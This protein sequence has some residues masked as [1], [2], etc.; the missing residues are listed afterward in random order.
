MAL[1]II[2]ALVLIPPVV[3]ILGWAPKWLFVL[4]LIAVVERS[5]YEFVLINRR[6]GIQCFAGLSYC[7]GGLLCLAQLSGLG[8]RFRA[9]ALVVIV[10]FLTM[11]LVLSLALSRIK[12][13]RAYQPAAASTIFGVLYIGLTLSSLVPLRFSSGFSTVGSGRGLIFLL[14]LVVW[15]DDIFAYFLG[16][17]L[18]H[19]P[20]LPRVSPKKTVEGSI[21]GFFGSALVGFGF[22]RWFWHP[23]DSK[24]VILSVIVIA[25]AGQLGDLVESALKRGAD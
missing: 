1:R 15:A 21:G 9:G 8:S 18:G 6:A 17:W 23:A 13:L 11:L 5:L 20:L 4:V 12:D 7:A 16:R 19:R 24:T 2:T 3:Y 10:V 25:I 22:A 14:F